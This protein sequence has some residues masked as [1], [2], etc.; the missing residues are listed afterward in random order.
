MEKLR[1]QSG[2][3][4][5]DE[6]QTVVAT[7]DVWKA[8]LLAHPTHAKYQIRSFIFYDKIHDLCNG[9]IPT[10]DGKYNPLFKGKTAR[11]HATPHTQ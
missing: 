8:Y 5:D 4:W 1:S 7:T 11:L 3:G 10:G 2:F 9:K 6:K